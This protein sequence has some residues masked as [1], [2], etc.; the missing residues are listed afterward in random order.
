MFLPKNVFNL[1]LTSDV[2]FIMTL[3]RLPKMTN[4]K[5]TERSNELRA[6]GN[7]FYSQRKFFDALL[8]YNESLCYSPIDNESLGHA[9]ANKSAIYI[10]M[11][12]YEKCLTNI[13]MAKKN[14]YPEKSFEVLDKR[15]EKCLEM[16]KV[17]KE[18]LSDPW[19]IFKL[20]YPPNK[21]VPF[22]ADCLEVESNEK[23]GR[24]V[25]ANRQ[26]KVGDIL[27]I[28]KPFCSVLMEE[29]TFHETS[30]PNIYQRCSNCLKEN[31]LDLIPCMKCCKGLLMSSTSYKFTNIFLYFQQCFVQPSVAKKL[32]TDTISTNAQ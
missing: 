11:K 12:L 1:W 13:E 16:L 2:D 10:E 4:P 6:E 19:T 26:L 5:S 18:K 8:K 27:A 30:E 9:Y 28:E 29:S 14:H 15:Q 21:N 23:Y 20:S 31:A 17:S 24:Y 22:V 3:S 25:I 7:K 32:S